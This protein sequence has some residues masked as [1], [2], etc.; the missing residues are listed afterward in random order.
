MEQMKYKTYLQKW[1]KKIHRV[2]LLNVSSDEFRSWLKI[3]IWNSTKQECQIQNLNSRSNLVFEIQIGQNWM[4]ERIWSKMV[5]LT[6]KITLFAKKCYLLI[7]TYS[8]MKRNRCYLDK[9]T[10]GMRVEK[11]TDSADRR[12][13]MHSISFFLLF[14][15]WNI[16]NQCFSTGGPRSSFGR[17]SIFY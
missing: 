15:L 13:S 9:K 17:L 3:M 8:Q 4:V 16:L 11:S 7:K 5:S 12:S 6:K 14:F 10:R 2:G 1:I